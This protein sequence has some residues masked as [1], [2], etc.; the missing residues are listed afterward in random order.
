MLRS[1]RSTALILTA[2]HPADVAQASNFTAL[3]PACAYSTQRSAAITLSDVQR[4][5][6][7]SVIAE[8]DKST[9]SVVFRKF[10][11]VGSQASVHTRCKACVN[12]LNISEMYKL[13]N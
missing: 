9:L 2:L 1:L 3:Q 8:I 5:P 11:R 7:S 12:N 6:R 10:Q 13:L 4:R